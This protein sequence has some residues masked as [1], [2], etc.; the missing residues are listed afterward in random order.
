MTT[1]SAAADLSYATIHLGRAIDELLAAEPGPALYEALGKVRDLRTMQIVAEAQM[2]EEV[3]LFA[4]PQPVA[5]PSSS[6]AGLAALH[7]R[8]GGPC[9]MSDAGLPCGHRAPCVECTPDGVIA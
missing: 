5:S 2:V 8:R 6:Q 7:S 3:R 4:A 1:L 9:S